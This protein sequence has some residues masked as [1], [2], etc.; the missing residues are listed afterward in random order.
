MYFSS[1]IFSIGQQTGTDGELCP[2]ICP[3]NCDDDEIL[4]PGGTMPNTCKENDYCHS[5]GVGSDGNTCPGY[6]PE[7]CE[8]HEMRCPV[9]NDPTTGCD[10]R[11]LCVPEQKDNEGNIC[12]QQQWSH[13][14]LMN[15]R[16]NFRI[17]RIFLSLKIEKRLK[18]VKN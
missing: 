18:S 3:V 13:L 1:T 2:L 17:F 12:P 14:R 7:E 10:V 6:C 16:W 15:V 8:D 4:C 5:K 9:P 11:P